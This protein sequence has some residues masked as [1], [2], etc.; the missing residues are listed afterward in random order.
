MTSSLVMPQPCFCM[1]T[2]RH[3][4]LLLSLEQW[5][6]SGL[7]GDTDEH[8]GFRKGHEGVWG[9]CH[10]FRRSRCVM[11]ASARATLRLEGAV[12]FLLG[13]SLIRNF[14]SFSICTSSSLA[15]PPEGSFPSTWIIL[16]AGWACSYLHSR[17]NCLVPSP[18]SSLLCTSLSPSLFL[19]FS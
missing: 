14:S 17:G 6:L 1:R 18:C 2:A 16:A 7:C 4:T 10:I 15:F 19:F 8:S 5:H 11:P 12:G 13:A 9:L 3:C